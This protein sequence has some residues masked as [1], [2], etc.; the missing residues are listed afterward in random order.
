MNVPL[1]ALAPLPQ[2]LQRQHPRGHGRRHR[3]VDHDIDDDALRHFNELL[4][5]LDLPQA[6][7]ASDQLASAARELLDTTRG[8]GAPRCIQQRMRR[9]AAIDLMAGDPDWELTHAD[10]GRAK[11]VLVDYLLGSFGLIPRT[12]KVVGRL[13]DAIVVEAAWP[14]LAS[15]VGDY[16]VFRRL[17]HVEALL[18]GESRAHFGFTRRQY[19]D[20]TL[21][22]AAWI[23][24]CERVD[25][26]SYLP[27]H[28]GPS[29][30]I[31]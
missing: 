22:E 13:D 5:Y 2:A 21:A 8:G 30:R 4:E 15:E 9:A 19:P 24:H 16:L 26:E 12:V 11:L 23:A 18:R 6:P 28:A 27:S 7:L 3:V 20:A 1:T 31:H 10:A 29:F 14:S 17:R 25:Q